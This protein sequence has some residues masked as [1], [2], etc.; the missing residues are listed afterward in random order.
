M[1]Y[2]KEKRTMCLP[3][4][5]LRFT[6]NDCLGRETLE[7][8]LWLLTKNLGWKFQSNMHIFFLG[9]YFQNVIIMLAVTLQL[10]HRH[11]A[12]L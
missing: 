9:K 1:W 12:F 6:K 7:T 2:N 11:I 4:I 3:L 10:K 8:W 5:L